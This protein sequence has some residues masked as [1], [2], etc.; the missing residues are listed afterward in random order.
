[1]AD[2]NNYD[3]IK[4]PKGKS[5]VWQFFS[6]KRKRE[7]HEI[8]ENTAFCDRCGVAVK[9]GG[10]TTNL[11]THLERH[12][13]MIKL[14]AQSSV[15]MSSAVT[16]S[17]GSQQPTVMELFNK[18]QQYKPNSERSRLISSKIANF[19]IKD[20]RP[21]SV[22]S[23]EGFRDLINILDPNYV[24]PS[25]TYFSQTLIPEL[26]Q[27]VKSKVVESLSK[28]HTVALTTDGW[29]SRATESYIT[30]TSCHINN[31]WELIS[32]VLQTR[33]MPCSHTAENVAQVIREA[34]TE[35]KLPQNPPLVTDNAAN[36]L[37]AARLLGSQPHLGCYAHT[38]NLAVQKGLALNSVSRLLG[39]IRRVVSY[40]HR[41]TTAAA[42]L[43]DKIKLLGLRQVKL[44]QDVCTRW[45][46]AVDMV[47]RFLELQPAIYTALM[48]KDIRAKEVDIA[49][50]SEVDIGLAENIMSVLIPIRTVSTALCSESMP[51][52][53]L[54]LPLQ[55]KLI[56]GLS[57]KD[58]D[59]QAI[60]QLKTAI[61]QN[62]QP[63]YSDLLPYLECTTLLDPRFKTSCFSEEDAFPITN[64]VISEAASTQ[65]VLVKQESDTS[66]ISDMETTGAQSE[67]ALPQLKL[68]N[69]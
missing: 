55:K 9:C 52:A 38:L 57:V 40:F 5:A 43:R 22:V 12:H 28:S 46:S 65:K 3:L 33:A 60:S 49:T 8:I 56:K 37:A 47:E 20:L 30:I 26:Y 4:N 42:I 68:G 50:L 17:A 66:P 25:K 10:G 58:D 15:N 19:M 32:H 16:T 7:T 44:I 39:R 27:S 64:R 13:K 54:I 29:T 35:W 67:P 11:R 18:R 31:D 6:I 69:L 63:R 23:N 34:I 1:M 41:S 2:E 21:F 14:S 24:I 59:M 61:S 62:L 48:S 51:T 36:M 45:N 53:S